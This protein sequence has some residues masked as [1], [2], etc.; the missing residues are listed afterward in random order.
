MFSVNLT[1][2]NMGSPVTI[3]ASDVSNIPASSLTTAQAGLWT[4]AR[5][6][7]SATL[8]SVLTLALF[9]L[10]PSLS[11]APPRHPAATAN[12]HSEQK[13]K[14]KG[15][16]LSISRD[17]TTV[18]LS[19]S[20]GVTMTLPQKTV[21]VVDERTHTSTRSSVAQLESNMQVIVKT[22]MDKLGKVTEA[23]IRITSR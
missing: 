8:L 16:L 17:G 15:T 14:F 1:G 13:A 10:A 22:H 18:Q 5:R 20:G 4:L 21:T 7:F 2:A 6:G 19:L 3:A 11:A 12:G 9:S 23:K